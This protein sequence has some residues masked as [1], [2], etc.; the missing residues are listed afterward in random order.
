[1][2]SLTSRRAGSFVAILAGIGFALAGAA[3]PGCNCASGVRH[4][5]GGNG[6]T[7]MGVPAVGSITVDP[8]D[9][10]LDLVQG[11]PAGMQPFKVT[12]HPASGDQDVTGQCTFA[13]TDQTLGTMNGNVFSTGGAH[14][15]STILIAT[16]VPPGGSQETM[17]MANIHVR[18]KGTFTGPDCMGG[19][20]GTFPPDGAPPC[21]QTNIAPQ[22]YY[23]PDGV[24]LPPNMNV[25][26]VQWTP[27]PSG[28]PALPIQEFEIDFENANTDVRI[29]TKCA[30]QMMDT[31]QP[32][33][34]ATGGCELVLDQAMWDFIAK[35]NRGGDA[36]KVTVRATTDGSV[37]H[38]VDQ[39]RQHRRSPSRTSTAASTTGSRPSPAPGTGGQIWAQELRRRASPEEQITGIGTL[40][41]TCYGC[42]L[43]SRDGQRMTVN[44]DDDDSDD[45]YSDVASAAGRRRRQDANRPRTPSASPRS[46]RPASRPSRP[47]TRSIIGSNGNGTGRRPNVLLPCTTASPTRR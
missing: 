47:T 37:R 39:Q 28:P 20:C 33:P 26:A 23:P 6:N 18:V 15:G 9:V 5:D 41:G 14:G 43:L 38:A 40:N 13:L 24:L 27:F 16:F 42:H 45:E 31:G 22:I 35:S 19:G 3:V 1:M 34:A 2:T 44:P 12:F 25:M 8:A 11:G 29:L 7:D 46:S 32:A 17:G 30:T 10:T 4:P 36:V 21:A